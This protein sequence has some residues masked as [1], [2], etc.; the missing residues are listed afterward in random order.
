VGDY[1]GTSTESAVTWVGRAII[2]WTSANA[3]A[4]GCVLPEEFINAESNIRESPNRNRIGAFQGKE[5][6]EGIPKR[7]AIDEEDAALQIIEPHFGD[8][9]MSC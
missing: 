9:S 1:R 3:C 4:A 5:S 7:I 8:C 2:A 6:F